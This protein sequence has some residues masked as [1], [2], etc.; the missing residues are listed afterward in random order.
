[1]IPKIIHYCWFG[2]KE[3]PASA[4]KCIQS[5]KK[6]CPT[7]EI[8]EWN[9]QNFDVNM[10]VY[11]RYCFEN[12]K[13]AFLSDYVRL[14]AVYQ[15]GGIYLDTDVEVVKCLDELLQMGAFFGRENVQF[16]NSGLGFG[17]TKKHSIIAKMCR[18]YEE[19]DS[20]NAEAPSL[21]T[22]PKINTSVLLKEGFSQ[23]E[24]TQC[25]NGITVFAKDYFNPYND[26]TGR[27]TLT[28]NTYSIHWYSKSWIPKIKVFRSKITRIFHRLFGVD[29]F[30][31]KKNKQR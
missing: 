19:V 6:Y 20:I 26:A 4:E 15:E 11:T 7:Y 8:K 21:M 23:V 17:A 18:Y 13:W 3:K 31:R 1:M 24:E 28:K 25:I 16:I 22:C 9:E 12:K 29:C 30:R 2:G 5:W 14:F 27:L 10:N